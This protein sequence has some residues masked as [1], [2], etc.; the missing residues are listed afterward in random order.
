M[1][2]TGAPVY[3]DTTVTV[4]MEE[5][6]VTPT[7]TVGDV[8]CDGVLDSADITLAA[9]YCMSAGAVSPQGIINGDMNGDGV[10]NAADLS[11]LYSYMLG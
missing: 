10:L 7:I 9:A 4:V 11:A 5:E 8:N 1:E 2:Y 6:S 3:Q